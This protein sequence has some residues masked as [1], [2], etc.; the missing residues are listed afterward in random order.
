M[1]IKFFLQGKLKYLTLI[2]AG[3]LADL[4]LAPFY[5][6]P[7]LFISFPIF[8]KILAAAE[9]KIQ[10]FKIGW[11]FGFG[12]FVFGLY[13][14]ANS[15]LVDAEK[16]AWLIPFAVCGIPFGLA[17]Y[18]GLFALAFRSSQRRLGSSH[19]AY[20]SLDPR[21]KPE[22][23]KCGNWNDIILF[24]ILWVVFELIRTWLFT[25][26]PWNLIGYTALVST[27]FSQLASA[28]GVYLLSYVVIIIS[29]LPLYYKNKKSLVGVVALVGIIILY[30]LLCFGKGEGDLDKTAKVIIFQPNVEQSLK[31]EPLAAKKQFIENIDFMQTLDY[32][33]A[34]IVLWPESGAP[35]YLNR[36]QPVTDLLRRVAPDNGVLVTGGLRSSGESKSNYQVWNTLYA[37][38]KDGIY[39]S[40]DKIHLVPFG[41]FV[42]FRNYLPLE[43][44]T[45]G[46]LDFSQ[47]GK[48][49]VMK[50]KNGPGF[51]PLICYEV[52]FPEFSHS[53]VKPDLLVNVTNDGWFG[54]ST[55]PYQHLAMS[56]MRSIEQGVPM[57][58]AA[59]T[60]VSAIIDKNG[61]IVKSLAYNQ[62]GFLS[63]DLELNNSVTIYSLYGDWIIFGLII[64][65]VEFLLIFRRKV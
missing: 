12:Y 41:E 4:A 28:G 36:Q 49:E 19:A 31:W 51:L 61:R 23:D 44:I 2:A 57:L 60:G 47:G 5:I 45:P 22:D 35:Y 55:G 11:A 14:I 54:N 15:L 16:F 39:Q 10:A 40:Y 8:F 33:N 30:G 59:N 58:R 50:Y 64:I 52:T 63:A 20:S 37:I 7:V 53:A 6:F 1:G 65:S 21:V 18:I 29:L 13:W 32:K 56:Q 46:A 42:P 3:G 27:I 17:I 24:S 26:F 9:N 48:R 62:H 43:K 25:G 34:D 38:S